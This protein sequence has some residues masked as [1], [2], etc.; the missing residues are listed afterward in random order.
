MFLIRADGNA[1][2]GAG[3]LMRCLTI[4]EELARLSG[5]REAVRFVCADA[6]SA[7]LAGERGFRS[8][9]L[10]TDY[11]DM[12]SELPRWEEMLEGLSGRAGRP[13]ILVDS[14]YVSDAYLEAL[15]RRG[16]VA[17][18]DDMGAR[19]YPADCV[20]NYHATASRKAY[21]ALYGGRDI[22]MALGSRYVPLRR[23]FR[24]RR[25]IF[26]ERARKV[27]ITAGGGD[28]GNIAGAILDRVYDPELSFCLVLG[29]YN[30][31]LRKMRELERERDNMHIRVNV[32]DMAGLMC[33]CDMALTAGGSTVYELAAL[34]VPFVCFSCAENQ[35]ALTEY[36]GA[37]GIAL[38]AGAWHRD[39]G[40][41]LDR[42]GEM[43]R[44]LLGSE[45]LR[46]SCREKGMAMADAEGAGRLAGILLSL[47]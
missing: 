43:S 9:V 27:L 42:V 25:H 22:R 29:P 15:K 7:A 44:E 19:P 40:E 8:Y 36:L 34:G 35:E 13:V 4:A 20:V 24:D 32:E 45:A 31:H 26:R 1:D 10:G 41:T 18:M 37:Q 39:S 33:E 16:R 47:A 23:Q 28:A 21:E 2:I 14:Y 46:R 12:E 11:R 6:G 38:N 30:P 17:L 3:H 5:E